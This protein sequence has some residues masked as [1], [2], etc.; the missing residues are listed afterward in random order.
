MAAF[1]QRPLPY[2]LKMLDTCSRRCYNLDTSGSVAQLD[3]A[4]A[5]GA[6]GFW[7]ESSRSHQS[8]PHSIEWGTVLCWCFAE[9]T[10]QHDRVE[11]VSTAM[12]EGMG[13]SIA[14]GG[15]E[16][17]LV[18]TLRLGLLLDRSD[19]C[20]ADPAPAVGWQDDQFGQFGAGDRVAQAG[21]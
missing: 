18:G 20:R 4:S 11:P 3:R 8:V 16:N 6:E 19:Q 5:S 14:P 9:I 7:F 17:Q 1:L 12:I 15:H 2:G 10:L 13:M 21:D